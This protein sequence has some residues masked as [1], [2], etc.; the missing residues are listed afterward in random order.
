[1]SSSSHAPDPSLPPTVGFTDE[2]SLPPEVAAARDDVLHQ[3]ADE[4]QAGR[5]TPA[6]E[7]LRRYPQLASQTT[8]AV[9]VVYEEICLREE[10]G[11]AVPSSE[12][13]GR[14]PQWKDALRRLLDCHY[15]IHVDEGPPEFPEAG[16][17]LGE[18]Q[19]L[20]QLGQGAVGRVFL[21]TQPSLSD[22]PLV[23]KITPRS[24][25]EHLSLARLQHTHIAPLYS[26][27]DFPGRRLRAICMPYLGGESWAS[28]LHAMKDR[29]EP[30]GTGRRIVERL[31]RTDRGKPVEW[32]RSGPALHFL[33]R[34]T[35]VQAVCWIGACLADALQ[36]AHLR[37]LLH[38]DVK[39][40]N[41]LV[42]SDG[43]PMLLDFHLAREMVPAHCQSLD[44]LGGTRGYM[45]PEQEQAAA[46]LRDGKSNPSPLDGRSDI[47]SLGVLLY[48]SLTGRLPPADEIESRRVL[49]A[50]DPEIGRGLED[51][52]HKCLARRAAARYQDAGQ[53]ATDLR[54]S[55]ANLPLQGVPNRSLVERW[56][57]W[58][59]RKP[60]ALTLVAAALV[61]ATVTGVFFWT[62][63]H[64]RLSTAR[65]ALAQ[66]Q[67]SMA[68]GDFSLAAE[69]LKNGRAAV[70]WLPGQYDLK[71]ALKTTL[72][73]ANQG[74]LAASV[75]GLAEQLRF[76]DSTEAPPPDQLRRLDAGCAELWQAREMIV[77]G[78]ANLSEAER[79]ALYTD[80]A[81]LAI[82]WAAMRVRLASPLERPARRQEALRLLDEAQALCGAS[83][84][85][86]LARR[87]YTSERSP[88]GAETL[89]QPKSARD[90]LALGRY[91]LAADDPTAA[92]QQF[93]QAAG[94]EPDQ[95]W[96]YFYL[97]Q[98]A[99]RLDDFER[100]LRAADVCVALSPL[101][102]PCF[103]NRAS[104]HEKQGHHKQA[105][106]DLTRS[107]QL[108]P[109]LAV[110]YLHRG[111]T[112]TELRHFAAATADF[113]QALA[114][115][116]DPAEVGYRQARLAVA[117]HD[118]VAARRQLAGALKHNPHHAAALQLQADIDAAGQPRP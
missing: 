60:H 8:A 38:L 87:Q 23:V 40:S 73:A 41:V 27:Q 116:T 86:E 80:L 113:E 45:S 102:A 82:S 1:M 83:F 7:W 66:G 114:R 10:Q 46:A 100:A 101:T 61:V 44:R 54:C 21:A 90:H 94:L 49:R 42:G 3:M 112:E 79:D 12:V 29:S 70:D 88:A 5:H 55:L 52:I 108:D 14:F 19:L 30:P 85:L 106:Q 36:Y 56:R 81:D 77:S 95:F 25:A 43:Q 99:Y 110:A 118:L 117:Q 28:I 37:G 39:P 53:L 84:P 31:E 104:C 91:Y 92:T 4:W 16:Q 57:K 24:G 74:L 48:E 71:D 97:T 67:Q 6:E 75:H 11:E 109:T 68:S 47:Y 65:T 107:L 62:F 51:V 105:L 98:C 34:A 18:L 89:P 9:Q 72:A 58:R 64:E 26:V 35:Y 50:S 15:L 111:M 33:A 103:Y 20:R 115:G 93:E 2:F 96:A 13:Y 63:R 69:Q 76:L 22:R 17:R 78:A 59:R 32:N